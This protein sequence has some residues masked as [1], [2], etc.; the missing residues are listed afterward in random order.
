MKHVS[1]VFALALIAAMLLGLTV[2]A[3]AITNHERQDYNVVVHP[4]EGLWQNMTL[5]FTVYY[6]AD[7][8]G[9]IDI[10]QVTNIEVSGNDGYTFKFQE[11]IAH[12]YGVDI[13]E[14]GSGVFTIWLCGALV[15]DGTDS[16]IKAFYPSRFEFTFTI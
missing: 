1:K 8:D 5:S 12:P 15:K 16:G 3:F 6:T 11:K 13:S 2:P 7:N 4:V 9:W 14:D 10:H